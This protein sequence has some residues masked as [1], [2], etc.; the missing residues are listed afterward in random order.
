MWQKSKHWNKSQASG[1]PCASVPMTRCKDRQF[2]LTVSIDHDYKNLNCPL[3]HVPLYLLGR[4]CCCVSCKDRPLVRRRECVFYT[5]NLFV[6][7]AFY[8]FFSF[9]VVVVV[10]VVFPVDASSLNVK[11]IIKKKNV[12]VI[13][14]I[15]DHTHCL[16]TGSIPVHRNGGLLEWFFSFNVKLFFCTFDLLYCKNEA[17]SHT[18]YNIQVKKTKTKKACPWHLCTT[19]FSILWKI[20]LF[21]SSI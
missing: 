17:S 8:K 7:P 4:S 20:A 18:K 15:W 3:Y 13:K 11:I 6:D 10:V 19:Y 9:L 2:R 16:L 21:L 5:L 1:E 14:T 12:T